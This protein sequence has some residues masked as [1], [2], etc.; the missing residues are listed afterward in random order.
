MPTE[1]FAHSGGDHY[2]NDARQAAITFWLLA[3]F[4]L[5]TALIAAL[6]AFAV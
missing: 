3:G 6:A 2:T 4:C 5:V 1:E